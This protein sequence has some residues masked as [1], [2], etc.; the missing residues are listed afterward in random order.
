[1]IAALNLANASACSRSDPGPLAGTW[2]RAGVVPLAVQ[3][4]VGETETMGFIEKVSYEIKGNQVIVSYES[5]PMQGTAVRYTI[6]APNS[7]RSE[8]GILQRIH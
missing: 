2:R 8:F 7:L 3:F 1:M 6:I 4:R 5:G